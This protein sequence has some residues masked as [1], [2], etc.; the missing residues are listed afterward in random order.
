MR[1][2]YKIIEN[3][4]PYFITSTV[5]EW[6]PIFINKQ[7]CD[8]IINSL[9][10]SRKQKGLNLFAYVIMP[11]HIH[12]IVSADNLSQ[13]IKDFKS[14]TAKQITNA[15]ASD[16]K[17]W[18]LNQLHF[19]KK[20]YKNT[21]S[22]QVWQEG[23]HPQEITSEN[24]LEQKIDY[25]HDNPVRKGFVERPEYWLYSSAGNYFNGKGIADVDIIEV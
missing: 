2:R 21:S 12:L 20:I 7:Y 18:L 11:E 24:M 6:I 16:G 23:F 4:T 19:Y 9:T 15:A 22:Y 17:T 14:Y 5:V 13:I 25:I 3:N 10:Y 1:T 8:I